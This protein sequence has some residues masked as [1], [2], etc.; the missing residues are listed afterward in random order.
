MIEKA[1]RGPNVAKKL[2][3]QENKPG[4]DWEWMLVIGV[5]IGALVSARISG[6]FQLEWVPSMW[7]EAFGTNLFVR[8]AV[9]VE[10]CAHHD[11]EKRATLAS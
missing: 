4:V 8:L 9:A 5:F 6:T 10:P 1:V 3:Y 2:Y 11:R 7:E